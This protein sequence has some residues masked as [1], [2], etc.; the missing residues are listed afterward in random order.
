MPHKF[1][2]KPQTGF[3][4]YPVLRKD[5]RVLEIASTTKSTGPERFNFLQ[6][7]EGPCFR[8]LGRK[9]MCGML[10]RIGLGSDQRMVIL[11]RIGNSW[12]G[13]RLDPDA[14]ISS[15]RVIFKKARRRFWAFTPADWI[16]RTKGAELPSITGAS[17]ASMSTKTLSTLKP[18]SAASTC[19]IVLTWNPFPLIAVQSSV[20]TR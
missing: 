2:G 1:V 18:A 15:G 16:N 5:D 17:A 12:R 10:I 11:D 7:P 19:S 14:T 20:G 6:E 4:Q 9:R 3:I 13:R 8:D